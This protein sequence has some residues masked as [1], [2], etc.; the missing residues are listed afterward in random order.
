MASADSAPASRNVR[1]A[2]R[3]RLMLCRMP[4]SAARAAVIGYMATAA[5]PPQASTNG[6]E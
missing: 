5:Q 3:M 1:P 6:R 4:V 2:R